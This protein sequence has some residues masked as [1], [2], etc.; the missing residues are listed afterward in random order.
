MT[1]PTDA[2]LRN[3][4]FALPAGVDLISEGDDAIRQNAAAAYRMRW[5]RGNLPDGTD[6][7]TLANNE[8]AGLWNVLTYATYANLPINGGFLVVEPSGSGT[9][10]RVVSSNGGTIM[11]RQGFKGSSGVT[12]YDWEFTHKSN[13][14]SG[15][16]L[17]DARTHG[18]FL[19]NSDVLANGIPDWP[20]HLTAPRASE[21]TVRRTSTGLIRQTIMP[22][23]RD[24]VMLT[25]VTTAISPSPYPFGDWT[26]VGAGSGSSGGGD[27]VGM[28]NDLLKQDFSRRH[29]GRYSTGG[30]GAVAIRC[31]HGLANFRD[32]V[33]PLLEAAG[34]VPS[35]ALNSRSW[36]LAENSG[37]DAATVNS[38]AAA[39]KVEVWNHSATHTNPSNPARLT[40]EIVTGLTEL[41]AQLPDADIDG[42]AVPGVSDQNPYMGMGSIS[43]VQS[44]Y[45]TEAGRMI[46][47]HHAVTTGHIPGSNHRVLDGVIRQGQAHLTMDSRTPAQII[48]EIDNAIVAGTGLQLMVHPSL[49]DAPDRITAAGLEEV[50]TYISDQQDEGQLV[51]LSPYRMMLADSTL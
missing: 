21:I 25:R 11:E 22:L 47:S 40:E 3:A 8:H 42:W 32:K 15:Q 28:I 35:L 13:Y 17:N 23:Y 38:W 43:D 24:N 7:N 48:A 50:V 37:V 41:R 29:G 18:D 36:G 16:P 12:W 10:Q 2:E 30:R 19:V 51:A 6:V 33:L 46:L 4:G 34:I 31:D 26:V 20:T 39:G 44:L 9:R 5:R 14:P 27:P 45:S 1:E 49:I